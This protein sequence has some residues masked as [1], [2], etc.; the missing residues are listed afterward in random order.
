[1][2]AGAT[3][4]GIALLL[5]QLLVVGAAS[6]RVAARLAP[7][8]APLLRLLIAWMTALVLLCGTVQLLAAVGLVGRASLLVVECAIAAAVLVRVKPS[9]QATASRVG[10]RDVAVAGGA[11]AFACLAAV[12]GL[13]APSR[14]FETI[15]YHVVN[16][17]HWLDGG[18]LWTLPLSLP[19]LHTGAFPSNGEMVGTALMVPFHSDAVVYV[20][21]ILFGV[22]AALAAAQIAVEL[23][24]TARTGLLCAVAVLATR[25]VFWTQ[26]DS[27]LT[28]LAAGGGIAAALAFALHARRQPD[29]LRWPLLAGLAAGFAAGSKYTALLPAVGVIVCMVLLLPAGRRRRGALACAAATVP[30]LA[31]WL[32]RNQVVTGNP[33][34]PL[35][36]SAG[37]R[38]LLHGGQGPVYAN[39][40]TLA[41]HVVNGHLG[42]LRT[43]AS[44]ATEL[45]G[46]AAALVAAGLVAFIPAVLRRDR[47][48]AVAAGFVALCLAGYLATPLTGGGP[49]GTPALIGSNMRYLVPALIVAA[50]VAA[51]WLRS[52][53]TPLAL[54]AIGWDVV[55][56]FQTTG[57]RPEAI[58]GP[59]SAVGAVAFACIVTA[60]GVAWWTGALATFAEHAT[61]RRRALSLVL[62]GSVATAAVSV[63]TAA[64]VRHS[65]ADGL[66][67]RTCG[68]VSTVAVI[69][70]PDV[71]DAAGPELQR[72]PLG[73][74]SGLQGDL[75]TIT[76]TASF[77][78][79]LAL[80]NPDALVVGHR[81]DSESPPGW[82]VP[83]PWIAAGSVPGGILYLRHA[84]AVTAGTPFPP[85][86]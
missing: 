44:L 49:Q 37:G 74:G 28:D 53:A 1:M 10:W 11:V 58:L 12:M 2:T 72:W 66:A 63:A 80:L 84:C 47:C 86:R 26:V 65:G 41:A 60:A 52:L 20:T 59:A 39:G 29:Q 15:R 81:V 30:L 57:E 13:G 40:T 69:D 18:S 48:L 73:V 43:W 31:A 36:V 64:A 17:A 4:G 83:Q 32:V 46:V 75:E 21:P 7:S 78:A 5:V 9:R 24:S 23:G 54:A 22:F 35:A 25:L 19:G 77:D 38:V 70:D 68:P 71:R 62:A 82:K 45:L 16:A 55:R 76:D 8:D 3:A 51:G 56:L 27:L 34:Y 85:S 42:P 6:A 67:M 79:Q 33:L 14:Q 61:V 50:G